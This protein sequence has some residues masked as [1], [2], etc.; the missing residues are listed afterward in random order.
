MA[1]P[2]PATTDLY[3]SGNLR[4]RATA[5]PAGGSVVVTFDDY[6]SACGL[7]RPGFGEAF[8]AARGLPVVAV[9]AAG[10]H[11][12]Q[13]PDMGDA[14]DIVA[15][16]VAGAGRITTYGSSMGAYAALRF[17]ARLGAHAT[18][19]LSPQYSID[20]EL[21]PFDRRWSAEAS[22]IMWKPWSRLPLRLGFRPV[23]IADG[24]GPDR[25][26]VDRIAADTPI[27]AI[28]VAHTAHPVTTFLA[29]SRLL[30][31][32]VLSTCDGSMDADAFRRRALASRRTDPTYLGEL[33]RA[34]PGSRART[35]LDLALR[36]LGTAP[37]NPLV[38]H[39]V[40]LRYRQAGSL[41]KALAHHHE[42]VAISRN[43][44][45][46]AQGLSE[47]LVAAGALDEALDVAL[48]VV[49]REPGSAFFQSWAGHI[50]FMRRD[51]PRAIHHG[52]IAHAI[53]PANPHYAQTL[54]AYRSGLPS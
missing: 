43:A 13:Y 19:A 22:G 24:H 4:V 14:L 11:W 26:H 40:A 2:A 38:H 47:T 48:D 41:D 17:A 46:Y 45:V 31:E 39:N 16:H 50:C 37:D 20:V 5:V 42:A 32:A 49:A 44:P 54:A 18:L 12:Y 53:L 21:A 15:R 10:R 33:A 36:A 30:E 28:L 29:T 7:E 25:L 8:F 27:D 35:G 51:L 34:Q 6:G 52:A 23:V 3:R 1:S 9:L